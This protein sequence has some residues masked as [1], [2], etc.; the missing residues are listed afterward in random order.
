MIELFQ[1]LGLCLRALLDCC[2]SEESQREQLFGY[3]W[4]DSL[5]L[6]SNALQKQDQSRVFRQH[7]GWRS[8][9]LSLLE[10][11]GKRVDCSCCYPKQRRFHLQKELVFLTCWK[12]FQVAQIS[13]M[14]MQHSLFLKR[15]ESILLVLFLLTWCSQ[16]LL[17]LLRTHWKGFSLFF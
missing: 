16:C 15:S 5:K 2:T 12:L 6:G 8:K 3:I 7:R 17:S 14:T 13:F 9:N 10:G 4:F 1:L 11:L